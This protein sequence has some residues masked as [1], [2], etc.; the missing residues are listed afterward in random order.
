[1]DAEPGNIKG[2][3]FDTFETWIESKL[4]GMDRATGVAL[5]E[6]KEKGVDHNHLIEKME[7][8]SQS[9]RRLMDSQAATFIPRKEFYGALVG[10]AG[11]IAVLFTVLE[12]LS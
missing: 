7:K 10:F 9:D 5:T 8:Q 11:L 6:A 4:A 12:K 2:W 3:T 1:M